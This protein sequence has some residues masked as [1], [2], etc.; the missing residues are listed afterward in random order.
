MNVPEIS[1]ITPAYNAAGFIAQ[2]ITSVINQTF[3]LWELIVVDDGSTDNTAEIVSS[4]LTDRRI[5]II[6][7]ENNGVSAARNAG[8]KAAGG[9]YIA[10]LDADDMYLPANLEEKYNALTRNSSSDFIYSDAVKCD[11]NLTDVSVEKGAEAQ[12]LF[13]TV[14]EW[15]SEN[16]PAFSSNIMVKSGLMKEKF[17]FDENLSNCADRYMKIVLSK[18]ATGFYLPKTLVKYRNA[19]GSMSKSVKLLEH[20]EKY[21]I[22]KI[23]DENILPPGS[24]RNKIIANIYLILSGSWY[25]NAKN[26]LRAIRY[27]IK[28]VLV[29]PPMIVTLLKK[30]I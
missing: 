10:L 20:D 28:S 22:K 2:A 27:A 3:P 14:M 9:K 16:I 30:I 8:I 24:Y 5:K 4:Y 11:S 6:R 26:P 13:K 17:H 21:I 1:V 12:N 29:Y 18:Y 19:P 23:K 15:K 25:K 7:Q